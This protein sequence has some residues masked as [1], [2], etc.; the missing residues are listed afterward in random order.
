M[1]ADSEGAI[2]RQ[3]FLDAMAG[4]ATSV[5]VVTTDGPA[6]CFGVTVSA[7]ASV[8]ADPPMILVCINRRSPVVGAIGVNGSMTLNILASDQ[9]AIADVFAGRSTQQRSFDFS[10][11]AWDDYGRAGAR[12]LCGAAVSLHANVSMVQDVETHVIVLGRVVSASRSGND[13]LIYTRGRYGK[14]LPL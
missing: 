12:H 13:P 4:V 10:C 11:A 14:P 6:G 3:D 9:S 8:S 7:F 1:I 5:G 2:S